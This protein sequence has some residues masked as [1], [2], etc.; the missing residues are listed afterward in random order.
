M[1]FRIDLLWPSGEIT[2]GNNVG[3]GIAIGAV[4][5]N[6][7]TKKPCWW[8]LQGNKKVEGWFPN[9]ENGRAQTI[10]RIVK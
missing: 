1:K 5:S 9:D 8:L 2:E 6:W 10:I 3:D 4:G 7:W